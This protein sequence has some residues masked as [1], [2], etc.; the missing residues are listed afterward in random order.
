MP[1]S[2]PAGEQYEAVWPLPERHAQ[3]P[4]LP[5]LDSEQDHFGV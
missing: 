5:I 1:S 2:C 3:H 4:Q